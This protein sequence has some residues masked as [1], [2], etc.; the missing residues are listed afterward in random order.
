MRRG[1]VPALREFSG[2]KTRNP[3]SSFG[4]SGLGFMVGGV[5]NLGHGT[6]WFE[7]IGEPLGPKSGFGAWGS[8][9]PQPDIPSRPRNRKR[10]EPKLPLADPKFKPQTRSTPP[11]AQRVR[12]SLAEEAACLSGCWEGFSGELGYIFQPSHKVCITRRLHLSKQTIFQLGAGKDPKALNPKAL[13]RA[14]KP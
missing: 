14:K 5:C 7:G 6:L 4:D 12:G 1:Q 11:H 2:I 13:R 9:N 3:R 10:K 8:P